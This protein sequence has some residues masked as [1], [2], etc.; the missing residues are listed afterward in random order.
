VANFRCKYASVLLH[1]NKESI[2]PV[3][4]VA[5]VAQNYAASI[6]RAEVNR[7]I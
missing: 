3:V 4:G 7:I 6:P 2:G 5:A 1:H